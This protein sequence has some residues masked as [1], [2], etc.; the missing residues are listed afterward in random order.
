MKYT[1]KHFVNCIDALI[2][3][4]LTATKA[5]MICS[6][7]TNSQSQCCSVLYSTHCFVITAALHNRRQHNKKINKVHSQCYSVSGQAP[8]SC[9]LF[10]SLQWSLKRTIFI[11]F[12]QR[13]APVTSTRLLQCQ[14]NTLQLSVLL[15][16][17]LLFCDGSY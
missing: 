5:I 8:V 17:L 11:H 2:C 10:L 6:Q 14:S 4:S 9:H 13:P 1:R 16:L 12:H 3:T 15:L 7:I